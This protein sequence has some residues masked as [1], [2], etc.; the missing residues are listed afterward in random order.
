MTGWNLPPGLS[1][2]DIPGNEEEYEVCENCEL[3]DS[4]ECHWSDCP[5]GKFDKEDEYE[6]R[7]Y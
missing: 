4:C 2:C 3:V 6:N 5:L 1:V 7:R